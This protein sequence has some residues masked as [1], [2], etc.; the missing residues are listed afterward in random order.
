M[1]ARNPVMNLDN[2]RY[3]VRVV[4]SSSFTAAADRLGTQK[5]TLSRRI[6]QLEDEL[7][8]RLL[9]R[10]TRKLHLT[11]DGE[12]LFERCR[13]LISSLEDARQGL[14]VNQPEPQ[15]R[16]KVTM[17]TEL[18]LVMLDDI[19]ASF[20]ESYP[21][22]QMEVELSSRVIDLVEEGIDLAIRVGPLENSSLI[23]RPIAQ[24]T[25]SLY[26]APAYL[27][28]SAPLQ[29]PKDL[30]SHRYLGLLHRMDPLSFEHVENSPTLPGE[31][32]LCTNSLSL[33][34]Y[35][36]RRGF[37]IAR[38]PCLFAQPLVDAGQLQ[39]VLVD[40]PVP[41]L[42]LNALYPSRQHLNPKTRLFLDHLNHELRQHNWAKNGLIRVPG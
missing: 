19:M 40:Y 42:A 22:I 3:F 29:T 34:R 31:R 11:P 17:P 35:M 9:Q 15:G 14:S 23:A 10:T 5:S 37:G 26:A 12:E 1:A 16:L 27:R 7:G 18:A 20:M 39:P 6:S 2:L 38:L 36:A 25:R 21:K 8:I 30:A 28:R 33:L 41:S 4:E 32:P 24:V 13:D